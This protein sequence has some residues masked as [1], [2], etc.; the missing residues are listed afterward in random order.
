M[1]YK[2]FGVW[3]LVTQS[4][5]SSVVNTVILFFIV[6]WKPKLLFSIESVKELMGYSLKLTIASLISKGYT[7][8]RSLII[9]KVY[10][11][12]EL[13]YYKKGNSF[14]NLIINN[15]DA[16][17]ASVLFPTMSKYSEDIE[18]IKELTRK[19][20]K[21][22]SYIIF[23]ILVGLFV[24]AEPMIKILLTDKWLFAVPFMQITCLT[25]LTMTISTANNQAIKAIGRSD[26]LLKMEF[27]RTFKH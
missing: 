4:I 2:G 9:G 27:N 26:V 22:S 20:L 13:A 3:A 12:K 17:I 19:S 10:T 16:T 1:A 11:A 14:P 23:P 7:E 8:L 25:Q 6:P 24:V 15:V 21:I 5:L 18:K